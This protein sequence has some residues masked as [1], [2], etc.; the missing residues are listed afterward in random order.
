MSIAKTIESKLKGESVKD[1]IAARKAESMSEMDRL[2][3]EANEATVA[4][5]AA[6]FRPGQPVS[7]GAEILES[8]QME[9]AGKGVT[10]KG[11][12]SAIRPDEL[13]AEGG[14]NVGG[15]DAIAAAMRIN[16]KGER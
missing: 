16:R 5:T 9:L 12:R 11:R 2:G 1:Q 14:H 13:G 10:T 8:A 7:K 6:C 4:A 15:V 3:Y